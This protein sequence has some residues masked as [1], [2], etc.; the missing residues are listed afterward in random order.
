VLLGGVDRLNMLGP[1]GSNYYVWEYCKVI[2]SGDKAGPSK[3]P[4]VLRMA[5]V[6]LILG[7]KA[8]PDGAMPRLDPNER[9]GPHRQQ[10]NRMIT[11]CSC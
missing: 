1:D 4:L 7:S 2:G 8:H 9:Q 6:E 11:S 10:V 5:E 3:E